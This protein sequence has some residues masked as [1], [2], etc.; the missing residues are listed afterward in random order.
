MTIQQEI[1]EVVDAFLEG[2]ITQ[3]GAVARAKTLMKRAR[4]PCDDPPSALTTMMIGLEPE[5]HVEMPDPEEVR[6]ELLLDREV[7]RRG[8]PCPDKE[9]T[10][11][12]DAFLFAYKVGKYVVRCQIKKDEKGNRVLEFIEESWGGEQ[13]CYRH[14]PIPLKKTEPPPSKEDIE[15]KENAYKTQHITREKALEWVIDQ[16]QKKGTYETYGSLLK[17]YWVLLRQDQSYEPDSV[18]YGKGGYIDKW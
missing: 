9:Q 1:L 6:K 4:D 2:R 10:K 7:L 12:M 14:V 5:P 13:T 8:V 15:E 11:T 17:F 18:L 16:L 3:E